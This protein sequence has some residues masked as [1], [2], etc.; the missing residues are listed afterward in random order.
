LGQRSHIPIEIFDD[1]KKLF[2]LFVL[3]A[4]LTVCGAALFVHFSDKQVLVLA[5]GT[6]K[7]VD[8]IW[9]SESGN[10]IAYEAEGERVKLRQAQPGTCISGGQ[11]IYYKS[12]RKVGIVP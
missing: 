7:T 9:E 6:L 12:F 11:K 4:L 3:M 8:E 10:L 2:K 1:M 5:D